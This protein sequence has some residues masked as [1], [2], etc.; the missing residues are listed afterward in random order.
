MYSAKNTHS[1][2]EGDL[3]AKGHKH[4]VRGTL[5]FNRKLNKQT[6]VIR[7]RG[8]NGRFDGDRRTIATSDLHQTFWTVE[9]KKEMDRI[10]KAEKLEA[11]QVESGEILI[12]N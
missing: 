6:V 8:M 5:R 10:K 7:T 1:L 2:T 3:L 11:Q 9:T 4:I 12:L